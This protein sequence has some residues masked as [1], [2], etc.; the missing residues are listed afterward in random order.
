MKKGPV[1]PI[2]TRLSATGGDYR[3]GVSIDWILRTRGRAQMNASE[4]EAD[5]EY[6]RGP[7]PPGGPGRGPA[8]RS[9]ALLTAVAGA[10][11]LGAV[12]LVV[13]EFTPL[14]HVASSARNAATVASIGTGAHNS[15]ALLP[16]AFLAAALSLAARA[17]RGRLAM[18]A[19]GVLGLAALGIALIG[20]L[21]AAQATGLVGHAGGGYVSAAASPAIGFYLETLGGVVLLIA[22]ASGV[23]LSPGAGN[24]RAAPPPGLVSGPRRSA[25]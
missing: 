6:S 10:G 14:A 19:V 7:R 8:G 3:F 20:D 18:L 17:G 11:V 21:P 24:P 23:L 4:P 5:I 16:V 13:A 1:G 15:Y 25:S 12:L 22:A 9:G 2:T